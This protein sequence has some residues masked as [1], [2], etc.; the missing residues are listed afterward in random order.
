MCQDGRDEFSDACNAD[1]KDAMAF[2]LALIRW[3]SAAARSIRSFVI[4]SGFDKES[5]SLCFHKLNR[6]QLKLLIR[7]RK[8]L[9][10]HIQRDSL[11][12]N[13]FQCIEIPKL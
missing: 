12:K 5:I 13:I 3:F 8:D 4:R 6:V 11:I 10:K 1:L 2:N 9:P 7:F